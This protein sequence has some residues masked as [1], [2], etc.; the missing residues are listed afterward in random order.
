MSQFTI[1]QGGMG[2]GVSGWRLAKA[3]AQRGQLGVVSG[4]GLAITLARRLQS[5]DLDGHVRRAV[6]AFPLPGIADRA[7]QQ[8]YIADGKP[9]DAPFKLTPMPQVQL[10]RA[11]TEL[12]VLANFVEVFLA[13]EGHTGVVGI[14]YLEKMQI[15]T[16]PSLY[17]AMLADVDYVLIGAG[18]PRLIPGALDNLSRGE[19]TELNVGVAGAL[20][21]EKTVC[22]FDPEAFCHGTAPALRRPQF[23]AIISSATLAITLTRKSNGRVD[24]FVVEGSTAGGHNAPPRGPMQLNSRGEPIYS[25]RD[26]PELSKIR[27]LG[28]PFYLAGGYADPDKL[29]EALQAG[30]SGVQIGTAFAFCEESGI[31][32]D[33]KLRVIE[34]CR[35]GNAHVMTDPSASPTGFPFKVLQLDGTL[36]DP[37]V[38]RPRKR[39]CDLGYLRQPYRKPD[40]TIGYRCPGEP[41]EQYL[42]KGGDIADTAGKMCVCNS[43]CATVGFP[44]R[45]TEGHV[46]PPLITA[47]DDV[48][49]LTRFISRGS[50]SYT[51]ADVLNFVLNPAEEVRHGTA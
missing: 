51:A 15:P 37:R 30:A 17:G 3:V 36:S 40:G 43:L 19:A 32:S 49:R 24:G 8:Y 6:A 25:P 11:F 4:T 26:V 12:T 20:P 39:V 42:A 44:Q 33:L 47:G 41:V 27:D 14:N 18:V 45:D 23:L 13:K 10:G 34:A 16:L 21:G 35:A 1:I 9:A 5:G 46:E 28:L 50:N 7:M 48:A 29:T 38:L 22:S 31:D 2:V